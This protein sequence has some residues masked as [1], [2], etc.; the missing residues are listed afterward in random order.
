MAALP[1]IFLLRLT[2]QNL[3]QPAHNL[4]DSWLA[5]RSLM[6]WKIGPPARR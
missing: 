6:D 1:A 2:S 5:S 4:S 3:L